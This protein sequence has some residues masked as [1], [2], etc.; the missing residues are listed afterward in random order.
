MN[1]Y[2]GSENMCRRMATCACLV[3]VA[4]FAC[5]SIVSPVHA[6]PQSDAAT[7]RAQILEALRREGYLRQS[8]AMQRA[9]AERRKRLI[10]VLL[11]F[12]VL[13]PGS[14][15]VLYRAAKS[16]D[17]PK[18]GRGP[19]GED[20]RR[21]F[22]G[23][24]TPDDG[25]QPGDERWAYWEQNGAGERSSRTINVSAA[26]RTLG[27]DESAEQKDIQRIWKVESLKCHPNG[28][29]YIAADTA[30]RKDLE[31]RAKQLNGARDN[32]ETYLRGH[33]RWQ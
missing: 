25:G 1:R 3:L 9:K 31:E 14:V 7:A 12:G 16:M 26:R 8:T 21:F 33:G 32:M 5:S 18:A 23:N 28:A 29:T 15:Y 19:T 20:W 27:I 10:K 6:V 11:V 4:L 17:E 30:G 24:Q 22:D 13:V 2:Q